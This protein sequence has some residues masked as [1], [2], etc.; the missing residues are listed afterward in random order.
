[1]T[2]RKIKYGEE[3]QVSDLIMV[4]LFTTN[5]KDYTEEYLNNFKEH[6]KPEDISKR[7]DSMHFYVAC[8]NDKIVACG[9]IAPFESVDNIKK[10]RD[11]CLHTVF[12]LPE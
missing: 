6:L 8:V 1:M 11:I 10:C 9:A 5:I 7:A 3:K 12:V 4:A 2:I